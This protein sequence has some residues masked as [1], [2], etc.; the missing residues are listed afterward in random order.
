VAP[1]VDAGPTVGELWTRYVRSLPAERWVYN[2]R[3]MMVPTLA[4]F[5][6]SCVEPRK[7][8]GRFRARR[9]IQ[10]PEMLVTSL[11]EHHWTDWRDWMI[12]HLSIGATYR[13]LISKRWQAFLNWAAGDK[14]IAANPMADVKLEA[15]RPRRES[16][17]S[18]DDLQRMLARND[19]PM[20]RA[21]LLIAFDTGARTDEVRRLKWDQI[22]M[23]TGSITFS[24]TTA[25]TKKTRR[26]KMMPRDLLALRDVPRYDHTGY[27]FASK[28]R[29]APLSQARLWSWFREAADAAGVKCAPGDG[30]IT[31][32]GATRHSFATRALKAGA[33]IN[34]VQRMLGHASPQTTELYLHT[35][36]ADLDDAYQLLHDASRK[37]PHTSKPPGDPSDPEGKV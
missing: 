9:A 12:E 4:H 29:D 18:E 37:P 21:H 33:R 6:P 14:R 28:H 15:K 26:A 19:S 27:V 23:L 8:V 36:D 31:F 3:S 25:K 35:S 1:V 30:R 16:T 2:M 5:A 17:M 24:W 22:D 11:R 34:Q 32:H 10:G 13:N 20:F 7:R